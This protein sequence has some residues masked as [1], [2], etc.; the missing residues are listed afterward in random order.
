MNQDRKSLLMAHLSIVLFGFSGIFGNLL[1]LP[2]LIITLGRVFFSSLA[3]LL[4]LLATRRPIR[5]ERMRDFWSLAALGLLLAL[6]WTAFY[7][8]IQLS[9]VA[10]GLLSFSTF[11]VFVTFLEPVFFRQKLRLGNVILALIV[12]AGVAIVVPEFRLENQ[13]TKGI[14]VGIFSG[15]TYAILSLFNKK[16]SFRYSGAQISFYEQLFS[17]ICLLPFLFFYRPSFTLGEI[18]LLA[19]LGTVCT[20][21]AHTLF[22]SSLRHIAVQT[23]GVLTCLEPIYSTLFAFLFL[24][25]V[26]APRDYM[27]GA[28]ILGAA[29]YSTLRA[30]QTSKKLKSAKG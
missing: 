4:V 2:A 30:N 10:L 3:L 1:Q 6:H 27:G 15:F 20:G 5:L 29:I 8:A 12:F 16:F 17:C 22:I 28:I 26:P 14:L 19:L 7:E 9:T 23:A 13:A 24:H 25:E 11:P 21:L 18:G